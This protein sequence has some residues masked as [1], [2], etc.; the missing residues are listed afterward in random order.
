MRVV[1]IQVA[2]LPLRAGALLRRGECPVR[3]LVDVRPLA[4]PYRQG[5]NHRDEN[6]RAQRQ[7]ESIDLANHIFLLGKVCLS[8]IEK[9]QPHQ[10]KFGTVGYATRSSWLQASKSAQPGFIASV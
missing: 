5:Q 4:G 3:A 8:L 9:K 1:L 7:S 2:V 6:G 10:L